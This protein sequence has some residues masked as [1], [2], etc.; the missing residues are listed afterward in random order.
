MTNYKLNAQQFH[1]TDAE[2]YR[3]ET[4]GSHKKS[5]HMA[6]VVYSPSHYNAKAPDGLTGSGSLR[7]KWIFNEEAGKKEGLLSSSIELMMD[8]VVEPNASIGLHE[9]S[10][11]E[12]IYY[13]L[14]GTIE[15]LLF[16]GEEKQTFTL[17]PGDAHR[18]SPGQS[19]F[20]KAGENGARF[21]VV[22]ARV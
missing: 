9:H 11:T 15:V 21:I 1:E 3:E 5:E 6:D 2:A 8:T 4:D 22:S 13:L 19:H 14:E 20:I 17:S 7:G 18:I 12:E 10:K 16:R